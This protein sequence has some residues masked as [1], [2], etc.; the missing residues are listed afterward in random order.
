M[1]DMR[2]TP[3]SSTARITASPSQMV[4]PTCIAL[5]QRSPCWFPLQSTGRDGG[6]PAK[7]TS[8]CWVRNG[9]QKKDG[10][11]VDRAH[12]VSW[13]LTLRKW[14]IELLVPLKWLDQQPTGFPSGEQLV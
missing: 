12:K 9:L 6:T 13:P 7:P 3:L 10:K 2:T 11:S 5:G 1:L 14:S 8:A 4:E